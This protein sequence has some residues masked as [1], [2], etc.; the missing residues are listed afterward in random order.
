MA[1]L[2]KWFF[3]FFPLLKLGEKEELGSEAAAGH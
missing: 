1:V 3:S 2:G